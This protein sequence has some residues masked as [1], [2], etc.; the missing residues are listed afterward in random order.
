MNQVNRH[1]LARIRSNYSRLSDKEKKIADYILQQ[2]KAIIHHTINQIADE[3]EV[4]ESTVFRFCQ[5]VGFK[6]YQALKI[7]LAAEVVEPVTDIHEKI[8]AGDDIGTVSE[9][10]FRSNMKT[11]EDT[12]KIT[13]QTALNDAVQ[14][15]IKAERVE[16]FGI[17]GSAIVS[18]DAYHKFLRSGIHVYAN[19][20]AHMQLMSASQLGEQDVAVIISHSGSTK[21]IIDIL[22]VLRDKQVTTIAITNFA[23]SSLSKHADILLY[24]VSEET[25]FR[26]EA[27]SSRIAELTLI[28]ALYTNVMLA[29][30]ES[31]Q[32]ALQDMRKAIA[33]K[34]L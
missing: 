32:Q 13:D 4:A 6:G 5:R 29:K 16:F 34:R 27:L 22:H 7:A 14:A 17:G 28:D 26:P 15:L 18:I 12:L 9:K 33:L 24:T 8:Q 20:D 19:L 2:P 23:K 10:V 21:D 25:E 3:L 1:G 11:L 30:G 31:A